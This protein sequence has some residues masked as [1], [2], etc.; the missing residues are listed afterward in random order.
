MGSEGEETRAKDIE[1]WAALEKLSRPQKIWTSGRI[2]MRGK[3]KRLTANEKLP[4][5]Q[6][7]RRD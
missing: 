6:C 3:K 7:G 4:G 2:D 5:Y 1:W